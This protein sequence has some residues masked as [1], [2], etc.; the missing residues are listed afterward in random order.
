[1]FKQFLDHQTRSINLAAIILAITSLLSAFLGFLRDRFLAKKFG[2]GDELDIYY[3]AFRIPDFLTMVLVMGAIS[4]AI[5][6]VFS[7]YL[8][9]SREDSWKFLANLFNLFLFFLIITSLILIFFAPQL[10]NLIA[11]GFSETKKGLTVLL[12]RIMFFSPLLLGISN[13]ISS[14]LRVFKRF[15]VTTLASIMYNLGIII[16]I[17]FFVPFIGLLG[18]AWGVVLGAFLHLLIQVPVLFKIGFRPQKIFNFQDMGFKKVIKLTLPRSIGLAAS[19]INLVVMTIIA[20][21]L[22]SG[23]IAVFNLAESLTRPFLTFIGISF[24]TAAFP[25]LALAFSK[26][27]KEKFFKMFFE[28]F[29]KILLLIVPLSFL[30]FIFRDFIIKLVLQTGKFGLVD[31]QLVSACFALFILGLFA[32]SLT[33]LLAKTFYAAQNTKIPAFSSIVAMGININLSFL[34]V[35]LLSFPNFFQEFFI[36]FFGLQNLKNIEIIG[37]P[38]ASSIS[39]IFQF[40]LLFILFQYLKIKQSSFS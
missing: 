8:V 10:I 39:V 38:L 30:L 31:V 20:S 35:W 22:A 7:Q 14:V 24:S 12:T 3:T 21:G 6:P 9:R 32:Q 15:L 34:F 2:A 25:F 40:L 33:L 1:M 5:I 23:G 4:A 27:E 37:L 36:N 16:G 18:L 13:I 17:L 29:S 19:Q 28:T 26:K 11:P